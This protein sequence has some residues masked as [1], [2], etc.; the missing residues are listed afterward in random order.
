MATL[1]NYGKILELNF[2]S[3][4]S[5]SDKFGKIQKSAPNI[6]YQKIENKR[7]KPSLQPELKCSNQNLPQMCIPY[8]LLTING[9]VD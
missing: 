6:L 9:H 5:K 7:K 3:S 8:T 4:V 1:S 2:F